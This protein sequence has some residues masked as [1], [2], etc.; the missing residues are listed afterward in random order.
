MPLYCGFD[1][2]TQSLTTVVIEAGEH[3]RIAFEHTLSFDEELP[4]YGTT[5]GVLTSADGTTVV[6]PPAL[7][8][9]ALDRS[10]A[11]LSQSG[12]D[13]AQIR[14]VSGSAQQHGSVYLCESATAAFGSHK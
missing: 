13:V 8:A 5:H 14:A 7:W 3:R 12:I 9:E 1:S 10:F 11:V 2:S 6:A 4:R